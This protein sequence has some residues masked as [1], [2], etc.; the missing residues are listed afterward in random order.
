MRIQVAAALTGLFAVALP[1][2]AGAEPAP[3]IEPELEVEVRGA[4]LTPD[5]AALDESVAGS[6]VRRA[7]LTR[8]GLGAADV[9][10]TAVGTAVTESGG[11]GAT[12]TAS[13]R[14]ATSAQTPVYLGGVRINDDIGGSADLSTVPL[15][16][17]DRVEIYRGNAPFEADRFGIGGAIFF[18]PRRPDDTR[19]ALGAKVGSFGSGGAFTYATA[20]DDERALLVG[21]SLEGAQNDYSF[22]GPGGRSERLQ[23][24]DATLLDL[25]LIAR[26]NVGRGSVEV[27]ANRFVREQGAQ[28][29]AVTPTYESRLLL[30]RTLASITGR[31]PLGRG[32]ALE[33]R[34]TAVVADSA[35]SDPRGELLGEPASRLEQLGDRVEQ[36]VAG[37]F[38]PGRGT[39]LR[40]ALRGGGERLRRYEA[41]ETPGIGPAL[42]VTRT[43]GRVVGNAEH[44]LVPWLSLRAL[45]ALECEATSAGGGERRCDSLEP[46]GRLGALARNGPFSGF[47]G[48]GRYAQAPTLGQL[49]GTSFVVRGNPA[50]VAESGITLDLGARFSRALPNERRPLY[51]SMS[52]YVRRATDL[53][54]YVRTSES[55]VTPVNVGVADVAG[56]ELEGGFGFAGYFAAGLGVTLVDFR[57]RT[58][59][60]TLVNDLL[61]YHSRLILAPAVEATTPR[62]GR[63]LGE[64]SLRAELV[65][66]SNRY[67]DFAG[68]DII[69]EQASLNLD[70]ALTW[71]ERALFLRGRVADVLDA[72]RY[73]VVGFPLPRRSFFVSLELRTGPL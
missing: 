66:Q 28:R 39:R 27:L 26:A 17:I 5:A 35:L 7:E 62:F 32:A 63:V 70:A 36:E 73:D 49:H 3:S 43:S 10:R 33:L 34:T 53:V 58:P 6:T 19:A 15:W 48:V 12:A 59:G 38:E 18:E 69:P 20:G 40:V 56:L 67:A 54:T 71:F 46:V 30:Q 21:L 37:R 60:R 25:W 42:D 31:A 13:I 65:Y 4:P 52:A 47:V 64:A 61:P 16:L 14:G 8:P 23:N 51:T 1:R 44:E 68:Q 50:L 2:L 45:L 57:D 11:L 9:L 55:Y 24:A 29:L 41:A 22:R 72:E